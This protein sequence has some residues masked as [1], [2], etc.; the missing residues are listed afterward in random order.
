MRG[1]FVLNPERFGMEPGTVVTIWA[2]AH[3]GGDRFSICSRADANFA[4]PA[5]RETKIKLRN[6]K[7]QT[8]AFFVRENYVVVPILIE[9]Y[10]AQAIVFAVG[11]YD[12]G[13]FG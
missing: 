10:E 7:M 9:V 5:A 12:G 3:E 2:G 8:V 13:A 11:V 4:G 6:V 1:F